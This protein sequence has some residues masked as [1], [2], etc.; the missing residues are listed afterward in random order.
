MVVP[1]DGQLLLLNQ[2][3]DGP[4]PEPIV[5]GPAQKLDILLDAPD[6]V[7]HPHHSAILWHSG[8]ACTEILQYFSLRFAST[9][10]VLP[11]LIVCTVHR[12]LHALSVICRGFNHRFSSQD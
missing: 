8:S 10:L 6:P 7:R 11:H 1:V 9:L 3:M 12:E 2:P 5:L 4:V